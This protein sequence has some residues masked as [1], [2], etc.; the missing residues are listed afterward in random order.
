MKRRRQLLVLLS[1]TSLLLVVVGAALGLAVR[2]EPAFYRRVA[3]PPG[4]DRQRLAQEFMSRSSDFYNLMTNGQPWALSFSQQQL[5]AYLQDENYSSAGL[6]TFPENVSDPRVEFESDRIRIGFRYGSGF[7]SAIVSVDLRTWLVA[8][9]PNVIA[10]ELC[11]MSVGGVPLGSHALMEYVTEAAREWN[12]DVTWYRSG[13]HPV[14]LVRLQANQSRPTFQ[15]R[16][17]EVT[18][19]QVLVHGKPTTDV[20]PPAGE[21]PA[22]PP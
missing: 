16:R 18:A 11:G 14:A 15:L 13:H 2:H 6:F 12:A 5:D 9:E 17:L 1:A 20:A 8:R 19:G 10:L 7:W 3:L 22:A 4:P 21:A